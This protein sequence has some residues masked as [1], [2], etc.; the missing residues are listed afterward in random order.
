[1]TSISSSQSSTPGQRSG[2]GARSVVEQLASDAQRQAAASSHTLERHQHVI[3][4]VD[5]NE[6]ACYA[7]ART[8]RAGGY[9]TLQAATSVEA[10]RLM[11]DACGLVADIE[12]PDVDG[13]EL[14]RLVR[15]NPRTAHIPIVHVS[16]KHT[17]VTDLLE[18]SRSGADSFLP[19]P[20][21][22]VQLLA[23]MDALLLC[24]LR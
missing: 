13:M 18:S 8:L 1:M 19:V 5:D 24:A 15:A 11:P 3:L 17:E 4:V 12:L 10:L 21:D 6:A 7:M 20:V 2:Q 16:A 23:V 9:H 14:C 22:P